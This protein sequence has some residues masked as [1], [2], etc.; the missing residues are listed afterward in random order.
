MDRKKLS[1]GKLVART[2]TMRIN[3]TAIAQLLLCLVV[4]EDV[5]N[6]TFRLV[7]KQRAKYKPVIYVSMF[8]RGYFICRY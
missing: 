7:V 8:G 5:R 2:E 4:G 6:V 3:G 1:R